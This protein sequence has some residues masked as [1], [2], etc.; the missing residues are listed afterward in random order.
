MILSELKSQWVNLASKYSEDNVLINTLWNNISVNYSKK[1]RYYHNLYHINSMLLQAKENQSKF[2]DYE[3]VNFAIWYHDI[4]YKSTKK[5]NEEKSAIFAKKC[6]NSLNFGGKRTKIIQNLIISTKKHEVVLNE[7]LD[8]SY[9]LDFDLSI[10]GTNW[11]SYLIYIQSIRKEY[12]IY[13][14]FIYNPGRKK[15]LLHFL[16]REHLYFTEEY[17]YKFESQARINIKKEIESL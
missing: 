14:S 11:E 4:I 13:P 15:V 9:L 7:N 1:N 8:N 10:L 6:L 16:E 17:K 12:K 2:D 3:A 5:D